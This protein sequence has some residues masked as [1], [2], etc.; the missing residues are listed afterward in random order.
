MVKLRCEKGKYLESS[1]ADIEL[2][3]NCECLVWS[4]LNLLYIGLRKLSI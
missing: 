3:N 2:S 4:S 1:V